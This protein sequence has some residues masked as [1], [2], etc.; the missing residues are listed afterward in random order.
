MSVKSIP[1][2]GLFYQFFI[3][4]S[5]AVSVLFES[6]PKF[7]EILYNGGNIWQYKSLIM[8]VDELSW[9]IIWA[10]AASNELYIFKVT[11]FCFLSYISVI[12]PLLFLFRHYT[13]ADGNSMIIGSNYQW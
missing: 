8:A 12:I 6:F 7:I 10:N 3:D 5:I 4:A 9:V 2:T 11:N 13:H 1:L